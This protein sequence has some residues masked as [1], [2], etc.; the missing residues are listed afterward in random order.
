LRVYDTDLKLVWSA[1][2]E[3]LAETTGCQYTI[4]AAP[5]SFTIKRTQYIAITAISTKPGGNGAVFVY[6]TSDQ[7]RILRRTGFSPYIKPAE[8]VG[9]SP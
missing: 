3:N 5:M 1:C 4:T 6:G 7:V 9:F 8:S 2:A